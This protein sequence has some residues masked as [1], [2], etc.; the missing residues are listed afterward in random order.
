[1]TA[2]MNAPRAIYLLGGASYPADKPVEAALAHRL[3]GLAP[4][5]V[6][7]DA[8]LGPEPVPGLAQRA[9]RL[10]DALARAATPVEAT[11]LI[12]RSMGARLATLL[13]AELPLRAVVA[14]SYPFHAPNHVLEPERFAHLAALAVPTLLLQGTDDAYGGADI[15]ERF[16]LAPA[17][18]PRLLPG[19]THQFDLA[20]AGWDAVTSMIRRF[21]AGDPAE[22]ASR[23]DEAWY[24]DRYPDVAAAVAGGHFPSGA[25]HF[26]RHGRA[27]GRRHRLHPEAG[28]FAAG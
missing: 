4:T 14:I 27:E 28:R 12:G 26:D 22:A 8:W 13:A 7:Q 5:I 11:V 9:A 10:R 24:L 16:R 20:P 18:R 21:L 1:M 6:P 19:V 15:T 2:V 17:I 23:F 3:R 25:D